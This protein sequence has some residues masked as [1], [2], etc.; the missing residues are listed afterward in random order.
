VRGLGDACRALGVPVTGGN[1]SF[2]NETSGEG[3]IPPTPTIGMVGLLEDVSRAVPA[4]FRAAGD[5]V[6]LF[7]ETRAE[8]GAS[9]YLVVRH[10][11][12]QGA[13]PA[14][15]LVAEKRLQELLVEAANRRLLRSAH[16]CSE[17]GAAIALAEC[18]IRSGF[19]VEATLADVG[20]R[21]ELALFAESCARA[22]VSCAPAAAETLLALARSHGVPAARIGTTGGAR[23]RITPGVDVA[24]AEAHDT[25]ARTLPEALG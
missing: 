20:G 12:E 24:L 17:G 16:D 10:G 14:L 8:L 5:A 22:I 21:S 1:V 19:G 15:D 13:P 23:I 2:Y 25:W 7:G 9:E 4:A 18:A 6:I 3:A 11:L